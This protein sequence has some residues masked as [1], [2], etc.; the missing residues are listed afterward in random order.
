MQDTTEPRSFIEV[1][2]D[3][4]EGNDDERLT[5]GDLCHGLK[6]RAFGILMLVL[7]L[8]PAIPFL[9]PPLPSFFGIPMMLVGLQMM[10]GRHEVWLP[11]KTAARSFQRKQYKSLV[12]KAKPWLKGLMFF[13]KPRLGF[14]T[15]GFSERVLGLWM[16]ILAISVCVPLPGTNTIPS[17]AI[18]V[19]AAGLIQRDGLFVVLGALF[20]VAALVVII[21]FGGTVISFGFDYVHSFFVPAE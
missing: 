14:L 2:E 13:M 3:V 7:A 18:G 4:A 15:K 5:I 8:P 6:D 11:R 21:F 19:I 12:R 1:L 9:P 20:G 10:L 17:I 16:A